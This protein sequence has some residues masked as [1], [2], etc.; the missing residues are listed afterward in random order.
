MR[1]SILLFSLILVMILSVPIY[2][3]PGDNA[4]EDEEVIEVPS[5]ITDVDAYVNLKKFQKI[6][7]NK[8]VEPGFE[9]VISV[10]KAPK[11]INGEVVTGENVEY[12]LYFGQ[13]DGQVYFSVEDP[14][15]KL[16]MDEIR[17]SVAA[18]ARK[19]FDI[20][21]DASTT[22][23]HIALK[24][25]GEFFWKYWDKDV[26][27]FPLGNVVISYDSYSF[28]FVNSKECKDLVLNYMLKPMFSEIDYLS[29]YYPVIRYVLNI[30]DGA[31]LADYECDLTNVTELK[32]VNPF[33]GIKKYTFF[34]TGN[35]Y[36]LSLG[37]EYV[38][39]LRGYIDGHKGGY[40]RRVE[41]DH[42]GCV[43]V[44]AYITLLRDISN[45]TLHDKVLSDFMLYKNLAVCLDTK[46]LID[47]TDMTTTTS[48][49]FYSDFKIDPEKL[50]LTPISDSV[51][52]IQPT[53]LE[54]F[55]Y[56]TSYGA[57]EKNFGRTIDASYFITTGEPYFIYKSTVKTE[58]GNQVV[59]EKIPM[60]YF[61]D[62]KGILDV[63]LGRAPFLVY[64]SNYEPY[65]LLVNW[66]YKQSDGHLGSEEEKEAFIN[67]IRTEMH[68]LG[69]AEEF[70]MYVKAAGQMTDGAKTGIK[71]GIGVCVFL[72]VVALGVFIFIKIKKMK[73]DPAN[74]R[75]IPLFEDDYDADDDDDDNSDT[76]EFK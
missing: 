33:D 40:D 21:K 24:N 29:N 47:V 57:Y 45:N 43:S 28:T 7:N 31:I 61:T 63:K 36:A 22:L 46:E 15:F 54:C 69:R 55:R 52:I 35:Y 12:T 39:I 34:N 53:Y 67:Q 5:Y 62:E 32:T 2:A 72:V 8:D 27:N 10:V 44:L 6:M 76:F 1:R 51:V 60:S 56:N 20:L 66:V 73:N 48:K 9:N 23:D 26:N 17:K 59:E 64:Y 50:L 3:D 16:W 68:Q 11:K 37:E 4:S 49:L 25:W 38:S 19:G 71:I 75:T 30:E 18:D 74:N 41:G 65:D 42:P 70:D 13:Y 14:E 58:N